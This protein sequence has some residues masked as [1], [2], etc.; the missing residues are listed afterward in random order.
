ML[1]AVL[2]VIVMQRQQDQKA[3]SP[4]AQEESDKERK[5]A[6]EEVSSPMC[7]GMGVHASLHTAAGGRQFRLRRSRAAGETAEATESDSRE[8]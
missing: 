2:M 4:T 7:A 8:N 1:A 5:E 3:L 6:E